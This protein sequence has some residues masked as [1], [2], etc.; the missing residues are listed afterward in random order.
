MSHEYNHGD[1][2]SLIRGFGDTHEAAQADFWQNVF[3]EAEQARE[4]DGDPDQPLS[5]RHLQAL[6]LVGEQ[7]TDHGG[8]NDG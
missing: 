5:A 8:G 1:P 3:L 2:A 6:A 4:F 7:P